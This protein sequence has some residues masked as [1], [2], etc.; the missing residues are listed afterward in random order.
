MGQYY[1]AVNIDSQQFVTARDHGSGVKLME[2][3]WL[4]NPMVNAV[5]AA[6]VP[7]GPWYACRL[8]WAGD[9]MDEKLFLKGIKNRSRKMKTLYDCCQYPEEATN[10]CIAQVRLRMADGPIAKF[11]ANHDKRQQVSLTGL[12]EEEPDDPGWHIH[13]LPLLTCSGNGRGGGDFRGE[14]EFTGSWAGDRISAEYEALDGY[15]LIV[16]GFTEHEYHEAR[17]NFSTKTMEEK[18]QMMQ[19]YCDKISSDG[20]RFSVTW[21]GGLGRGTFNLHLDGDTIEELQDLEREML[22]Y[23]Q[24]KM[25]YDNLDGYFHTEGKLVYDPQS[26]CFTGSDYYKEIDGAMAECLIQLEIPEQATFERLG[27]FICSEYK[28]DKVNVN[29]K[30]QGSYASKIDQLIPDWE[31]Q[32][33]EAFS[34]EIAKLDDFEYTYTEHIVEPVHLVP[35]GKGTKYVFRG[36]FYAR[37]IPEH[38]EVNIGFKEDQDAA[39]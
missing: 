31:R 11:V 23:I 13:P 39:S 18:T 7:A 32:L 8:V 30:P 10:P 35:N 34:V 4:I 12:P 6:M 15:E 14:N 25:G 20:F 22:D 2:H 28:G 16:P 9:Y 24:E 19:Q 1:K 38:R 17:E 5:M 37:S 3:S 26:K 33:S 21:K 27:I 36:F 29:I